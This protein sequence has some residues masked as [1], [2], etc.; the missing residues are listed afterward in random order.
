MIKILSEMKSCLQGNILPL[1]T[2]MQRMRW[3]VVIALFSASLSVSAETW[4]INPTS[5][6]DCDELYSVRFSYLYSLYSRHEVLAQT[7]KNNRDTQCHANYAAIV[8]PAEAHRDAELELCDI[9]F[10]EAVAKAS[11]K[12]AACIATGAGSLVCA[13]PYAKALIIAGIKW[14]QCVDAAW[15]AYEEIRKPA[16]DAETLCITESNDRYLDKQA[17]ILRARNRAF[18]GLEEAYL[19]CLNRV[20]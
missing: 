2:L 6:S 8:N 9:A 13:K 12:Y 15:D 1:G 19:D 3:G 5:R 20:P 18:E 4:R 17:L 16:E 14:D 10:Q 7:E 11:I